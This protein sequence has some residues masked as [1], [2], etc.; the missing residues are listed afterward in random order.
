MKEKFEPLSCDV[1]F[2]SYFT[3]SQACT[4]GEMTWLQAGQSAVQ[5]PTG[6]I[7]LS[8]PEHPWWHSS[9][10]SLISKGY[11]EVDNSPQFSADVK[12]EWSCTSTPAVCFHGM[13]TDFTF[14]SRSNYY[15]CVPKYMCF[16]SAVFG[17]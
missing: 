1:Q 4:V 3:G 14:Y 11:S 15:C 12:K 7:L 16:P 2:N 6:T 8:S 9:P 5:I 10:P 13:D 17:A